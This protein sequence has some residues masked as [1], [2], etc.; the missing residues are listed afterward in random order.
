[1]RATVLMSKAGVVNIGPPSLA[2]PSGDDV[3]Q[4]GGEGRDRRVRG[5]RTRRRASSTPPSARRRTRAP[6]ASMVSAGTPVKPATRAGVNSG[7]A[8]LDLGPT[9]GRALQE[10]AVDAAALDQHL[11]PS[12]AGTRHR[13]PGGSNDVLVGLLGGLGATRIDDHD[14]AAALAH[15]AQAPA[16]VGRGHDAAVR[17]HRIAAQAEEV[18]GAIDVGDRESRSTS[19]TA[20]RR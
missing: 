7:E 10:L 8:P 1:M 9:R 15:A 20:R 19:R 6:G 4:I 13:R 14:L 18:V 5:R 2:E 3:Q 11:R 17:D 16:H 12:P